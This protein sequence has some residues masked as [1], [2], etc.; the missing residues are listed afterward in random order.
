[1]NHIDRA[2]HEYWRGA[3]PLFAI[4]HKTGKALT[5]ADQ[6]REIQRQVELA[7]RAGWADCGKNVIEVLQKPL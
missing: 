5:D 4:Q 7:Y 3:Q 1:M 2:Y 6:T